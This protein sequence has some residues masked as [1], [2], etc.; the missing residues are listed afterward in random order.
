MNVFWG[1]KGFMKLRNPFKN[2]S[3]FELRLW[4]MSL[5]T[6]VL[7]FFFIES[8][9]ILNLVD[10]IIGVTALIFI[11]KGDV[12]GQILTVVFSLLYGIISYNFNYYGEMI[13]YLGMTMP[14]AIMSIVTWLKNPYKEGSEV[15]VNKLS[16]NKIILMIFLTMVVTVLF[17]FIL[18]YFNTSNLFFSIISITTSFMAS[19]LMLIR[20]SFY[21][22]AYAI[23]D[24][25][26]IVLWILA[27]L[28]DLSYI[29]MVICFFV[30][31]IN[32][33]YGFC[34][35]C[36]MQKRQNSAVNTL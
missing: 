30:F 29:S 35:W 33:L 7:S 8:K 3:K 13:T 1:E 22:I 4:L 9:S 2:L 31:F 15:K 21:A 26:L 32:D 5:L 19:Y 28:T 16:L 20:S 10:T 25:I 17:G 23:N 6:V 36:K 18:K 14:I 24:I 12:W 11:A 34:S 27:S